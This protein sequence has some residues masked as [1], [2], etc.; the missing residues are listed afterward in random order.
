MPA[1]KRPRKKR[2]FRRGSPSYYIGVALGVLMVAG[3]LV[4]MAA[5]YINRPKF[6][7]MEFRVPVA[8]GAGTK[9]VKAKHAVSKQQ[10]TTTDFE[11]TTP[12]G[13]KL[14]VGG[15]PSGASFNLTCYSYI[16]HRCDRLRIAGDTC[17]KIANS[18]AK[19][20]ASKGLA[21]CKAS[22]VRQYPQARYIVEGG[23][24][25]VQKKLP[26]QKKARVATQA[27]PGNPGIQVA[28]PSSV[29]LVTEDGRVL[30]RGGTKV[31]MRGKQNAQAGQGVAETQKPALSP[32]QKAEIL[33]QAYILMN[34]E[35][36]A[37]RTYSESPQMRRARLARL[38]ALIAKTK[39]ADLEKA[40]NTLL[41]NENKRMA[42]PS[43]YG[44][45]GHMSTVGSADIDNPQK[46]PVPKDLQVIRQKM[47]QAGVQVPDLTPPLE[48]PV[49]STVT[50][51]NMQ[52]A[53]GGLPQA[54]GATPIQ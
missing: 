13:L 50:T 38:R 54:A 16:M 34:R 27:E 32:Q 26:Q 51:Q 8:P 49:E 48:R 23:Q 39:D 6:N 30:Q 18:A 20:P 46:P 2:L 25:P 33:K 31:A 19:I 9:P 37:D 22:L 14:T 53:Q 40:F 35:H 43:G 44:I 42:R 29:R 7:A 5:L 45:Q 10:A 24:K 52:P 3:V 1:R 41:N 4:A 47:R 21:Y 15:V 12:Q 36:L 28:V 17:N 11:T